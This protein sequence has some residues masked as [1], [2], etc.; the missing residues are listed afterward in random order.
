MSNVRGKTSNVYHTTIPV[1]RI[2]PREHRSEKP[3][4]PVR[5]ESSFSFSSFLIL[6]FFR[7][8]EDAESKVLPFSLFRSPPENST[9]SLTRYLLTLGG[10]FEEGVSPT[11]TSNPSS[12]TQ[13]RLNQAACRL[14]L[15][16]DFV[17][18][19]FTVVAPRIP[20]LNPHLFKEQV[21]NP[22]PKEKPPHALIA[23]VIAFGAR[24]S[25]HSIILADREEVAQEMS[26]EKPTSKAR[27]WSIEGKGNS[28]IA[29][30]LTLKA[31]EVA[32]RSKA[33][34]IST[35]SN[36]QACIMIPYLLRSLP[37]IK[38]KRSSLLSSNSDA[39]L[40]DE[41]SDENILHQQVFW[42]S[43]A[44]NHLIA[45]KAYKLETYQ[46]MEQKDLQLRSELV[47]TFWNLVI[48]GKLSETR[49]EK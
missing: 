2:S 4:R 16:T 9:E 38:S 39:P 8:P 11:L 33:Y 13:A 42:H 37:N 36:V 18:A 15:V 5:R 22:D 17:S 14:E 6:G 21:F 45:L 25:R 40:N 48:S 27:Q 23:V 26:K 20:L 29:I 32:E 35:L 43:A 19:F 30:D 10:S 49:R 12:G 1:S 34:R 44:V 24:F 31:Q 7:R 47:F 41:D 3:K 46:S 28:R